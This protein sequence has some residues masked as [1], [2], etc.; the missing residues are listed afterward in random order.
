MQELQGPKN[1]ELVDIRGVHID[2]RLPQDERISSFVSQIRDPYHFRVGDVIVS[3]AYSNTD[4]SLDD[5]FY[6]L[7]TAMG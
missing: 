1:N 7:L 4:K 3:V 6:D 5:R 2:H